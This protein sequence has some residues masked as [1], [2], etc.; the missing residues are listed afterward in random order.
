MTLLS[1]RGD[2]G[3]EDEEGEVG[4]ALRDNNLALGEL[5]FKIIRPSL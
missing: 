5:G 1:E 2:K 4:V 3:E